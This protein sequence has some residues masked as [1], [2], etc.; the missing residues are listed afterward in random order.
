V[1]SEK[2]VLLSFYV[3]GCHCLSLYVIDI[4]TGSTPAASTIHPFGFIDKRRFGHLE[5][6][7]CKPD[8]R[9]FFGGDG[10]L[11]FSVITP[12]QF[13]VVIHRP[14]VDL[15]EAISMKRFLQSKRELMKLSLPG[16]FLF[17]F[18]IRFGLMSVLARLGSRANWYRLERHYVDSR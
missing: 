13:W 3:I 12:G 5:I 16:E 2:P 4:T 18:R 15:G 1:S 14:T 17:L 7:V 9:F 8:T 11:Q 6:T 10:V